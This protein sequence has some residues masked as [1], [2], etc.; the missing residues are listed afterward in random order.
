MFCYVVVYVERG[1]VEL[2]LFDHVF[3]C[4]DGLFHLGVD[5]L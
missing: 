3:T 5:S 1:L 2:E 4:L